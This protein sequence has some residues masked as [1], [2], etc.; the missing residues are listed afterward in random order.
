MKIRGIVLAAGSSRRMGSPKALLEVNSRLVVERVTEALTDGGVD[1]V[2]VVTGGKHSREVRSAA[3][4]IPGPVTVVENPDP[5]DGPVTSI[6]VGLRV[7]NCPQG[8]LI[9]PVDVAGIESSDVAA[10]IEAANSNADADAWVPSIAGRQAHPVLIQRESA[11]RLLDEGG[12]P[13]L[14]ALLREPETRV[15]HVPIDAPR[16]LQDLDEP[17]DLPLLKRLLGEK[18]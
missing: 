9:H 16:L 14:R 4:K 17:G 1:E 13:H 12:P 10:L 6:R 8:V 11:M 3:A 5:A 15:N 7:E 2:L 18:S